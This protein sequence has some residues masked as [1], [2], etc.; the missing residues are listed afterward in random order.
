MLAKKL[1]RLKDLQEFAFCGMPHVGSGQ[2]SHLSPFLNGNST[3]RSL[4]LSG[5]GLNAEDIQAIRVFFKSND[6]L[7]VL[8]LGGNEC[9]GDEGVN[10]L[11]CALKEEKKGLLAKKKK[12]KLRTLGL[13]N[14]GMG[15][16][17]AASISEFM[18][19]CKFNFL[20]FTSTVSSSVFVHQS[21]L[22]RFFHYFLS[23]TGSSLQILELSHNKIGDIGAKKIAE[24]IKGDQCKLEYLGLN[25]TNLG[26]QG[27][28]NLSAS[29]SSNCSLR[30]LTLRSNSGIT[31]AGAHSLVESIYNPTSI[32][33]IIES[34]HTLRNL[35]LKGCSHIG[36]ALLSSANSFSAQ[37][38]ILKS[39]KDVIRHKIS[40]Y[41]KDNICIGNTAL[42]A[43]IEDV[44]LMPFILSFVGQ[45]NRLNHLFHIVKNW[46]MP[47]L[48][49]NNH[50]HSQEQELQEKKDDEFSKFIEQFTPAPKT[51]RKRFFDIS[52][53]LVSRK[54]VI[55]RCNDG[56]NRNK[57][58]SF[59]R[60]NT[61]Q[62]RSILSSRIFRNTIFFAGYKT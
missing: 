9:L 32:N 29:L 16:V 18:N 2:I 61:N 24:S 12:K 6:S 46:N 51:R 43:S 31:D 19:H 10:D 41:L 11:V 60:N 5:L 45:S 54:S 44:E 40:K 34:N 35:D 15:H 59:V 58:E 36:K 62:L 14:C 55:L 56:R 26:D 38:S 17:G 21:I 20:G 48:F 7:R 4:N 28:K 30:T 8:I 52:V 49:T 50:V 57:S 53:N 37:C 1:K 27:A 22:H 23:G 47:Q 13:E 3:L 42:D 25:N 33:S 39:T